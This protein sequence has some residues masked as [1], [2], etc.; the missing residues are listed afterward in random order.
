[1]HSVRLVWL[2]LYLLPILSFAQAVEEPEAVITEQWTEAD[3]VQKPKEYL[4]KGYYYSIVKEKPFAGELPQE[5]DQMVGRYQ[6]EDFQYAESIKDQLSFLDRAM[7]R[8]WRLIESLFPKQDVFNPG[9]FY[10]FLAL[11]GAVL[12]V[13]LIY[14]FFVANKVYTNIKKEKEEDGTIAFVER[15]LMQIDVGKY[16][17]EALQ[18][19]DYALAIRYQQL[20]NIQVMTRKGWVEYEHTKTNRELLDTIQHTGLREDFRYCTDIFDRVWFGN[21]T[22][23][24]EEYERL[25]KAFGHFQQAW[26]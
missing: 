15:N 10:N 24:K 1:M 26:S 6:T 18:Q 12:I 2:Y 16:I 19:G 5:Y 25:S 22:V 21:F 14:R 11:L 13:Y 23:D 20:K 7:N 8:F 3:I 9:D 17:E 4:S